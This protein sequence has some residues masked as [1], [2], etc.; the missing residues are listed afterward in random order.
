MRQAFGL[1]SY[2]R[3]Q[4]DC[5]R[6][7]A[8][9]FD[10]S[11][12]Q[13][14]PRGLWPRASR[15]I[16]QAT[17]TSRELRTRPT[18]RLRIPTRARNNA[19][20]ENGT[21]FVTKLNPSLSGAAS[22]LYSTYLGGSGSDE[23]SGIAVDSAGNAYVTG[24][25]DSIGNSRCAG[26]GDPESCCTGAGTGTCMAF[27]TVNAYQSANGGRPVHRLRGQARPFGVGS[28]IAALFDLPGRQRT[29]M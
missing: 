18:S 9:L 6:S 21:A 24:F 7:G 25:T 11:R 15:S 13:R 10:L 28:G 12:R 8:A 1:A 26:P 19:T 22:L 16:P 27:P 17:R 14:N 3:S 23:G 20:V 29:A 5:D 4:A 2:D